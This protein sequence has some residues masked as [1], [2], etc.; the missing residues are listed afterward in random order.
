VDFPLALIEFFL[1][2]ATAEVLRANIDW[3]SAISL[4]QGQLDP[5]FQVEGVVVVV[6]VVVVEVVEQR[7]FLLR[8]LG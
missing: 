4:Q 3:K 5:K 8:K 1:L 7:N 2:G 6:V